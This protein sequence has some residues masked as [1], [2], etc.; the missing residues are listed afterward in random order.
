MALLASTRLL[1]AMRHCTSAGKTAACRWH[2]AATARGP[3]ISSAAAAGV[4]ARRAGGG[5]G[6]SQL[7][8]A[9]A[10]S[11]D[12][13]QIGSALMEQMRGKIQAALNTQLVE[14]EDMQGDGRHVEIN[15][16]SADFEGKS[17]VNRQRMVY[18]VGTGGGYWGARGWVG[19]LQGGL[20]WYLEVATLCLT[21]CP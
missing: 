14:V 7:L 1:V 9:R 2:V 13:G 10:A 19:G 20:G 16:I 18:K 17:A 21:C 6:H 15:V 5:G 8:T 3:A 4:A 11:S 12:Q